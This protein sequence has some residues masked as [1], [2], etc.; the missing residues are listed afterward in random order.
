MPQQ[1]MY[2]GD[3]STMSFPSSRCPMPTAEASHDRARS[4]ALRLLNILV[5]TKKMNLCRNLLFCTGSRS[6]S[7]EIEELVVERWNW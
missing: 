3:V 5:N 6:K 2:S 7:E 1:A 4:L